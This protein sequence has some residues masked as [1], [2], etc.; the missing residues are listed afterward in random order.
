[1]FQEGNQCVYYRKSFPEAVI[2]AKNVNLR[3]QIHATGVKPKS[4]HVCANTSYGGTQRLSNPW[5]SSNRNSS[6]TLVTI[7]TTRK[8]RVAWVYIYGAG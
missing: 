8:N 5:V 2:S 6:V 1:M 4:E 7:T 3:V